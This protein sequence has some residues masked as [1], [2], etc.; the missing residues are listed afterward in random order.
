MTTARSSTTSTSASMPAL[1]RLARVW[2][3]GSVT[4]SQSRR[5]IRPPSTVPS[6]SGSVIGVVMRRLGLGRLGSSSGPSMV[7]TPV[8]PLA[9]VSM[10]RPIRVGSLAA[11]TRRSRSTT[12][13]SR[14]AGQPRWKEPRNDEIRLSRSPIRI[15]RMTSWWRSGRKGVAFGA[16]LGREAVRRILGLAR[17]LKAAHAGERRS[18]GG[19]GQR[20]VDRT[21]DDHHARDEEQELGPDRETM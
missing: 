20:T 4:R 21:G 16:D 7:A 14:H 15:S 13:S 18:A 3:R 1:R 10:I 19:D 17:E 6:S 11:T 8:G 5:A 12:T 2:A 9:A